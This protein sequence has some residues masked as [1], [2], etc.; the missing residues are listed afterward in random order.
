MSDSSIEKEF[1]NLILQLSLK[2]QPVMSLFYLKDELRGGSRLELLLSSWKQQTSYNKIE[3]DRLNY[4][5]RGGFFPD[6]SLRFGTAITQVMQGWALECDTGLVLDYFMQDRDKAF[7]AAG[8]RFNTMTWLHCNRFWTVLQAIFVGLF[9]FGFDYF[10]SMFYGRLGKG[11]N[12]F[13]FVLRTCMYRSN[14]AGF[15]CSIIW[16][17]LACPYVTRFEVRKMEKA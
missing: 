16:K 15:G 7:G 13:W 14:K 4:L 12:R 1:M 3:D 2:R 6:Y 5:R 8:C 17:G 11:C 9:L 10:D